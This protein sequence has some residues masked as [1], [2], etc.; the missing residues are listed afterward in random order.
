MR[1][2][3]CPHPDRM[4]RRGSKASERRR[5]LSDRLSCQ[6]DQA[7]SSSIYLLR[8]IGPTG[9]LLREEEPENKDFRVTSASAPAW[10]KTPWFP[11]PTP[12]STPTPNTHTLYLAPIANSAATRCRTLP[13][14]VPISKGVQIADRNICYKSYTTGF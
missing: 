1:G 3:H 12:T 5:H 14:S 10:T 4:L 6:Q 2:R 7:L 13:S 9:F 8:E 11:A